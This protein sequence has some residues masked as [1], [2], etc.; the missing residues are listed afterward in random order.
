[1]IPEPDWLS[2]SWTIGSAGGCVALGAGIYLCAARSRS[3]W[4]IVYRWL[5]CLADHDERTDT[6]R[7]EVRTDGRSAS[8]HAVARQVIDST[9]PVATSGVA[10]PETVAMAESAS[11]RPILE[12]LLFVASEPLAPAQ[13]AG[14]L[15]VEESAVAAALEAMCRDGGFAGL[16]VTRV[17]GGYQLT[18][19]A[20]YA[21][22]VARFLEPTPQRLSRQALE[23]LAIVAYH[24]PITLPEIEALRGVD[25]SGVLHTL[26]DRG[27]VGEAGR[28]EGPGRPILYRTTRE[29]LKFVGIADLSELPALEEV[30]DGE[31]QEVR[32]G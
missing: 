7:A 20:E 31:V 25:S 14:V 11:L 1:M 30:T 18:T 28:K 6:E 19:R 21:P 3:A 15:G 2:V 4:E 26:I 23:T 16:E 29:F 5:R 8:S 32:L 10:T 12:C 17:A 9:E 13:V 27:L 24:Q 22:V